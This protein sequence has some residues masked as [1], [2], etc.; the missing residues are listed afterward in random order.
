MILVILTIGLDQPQTNFTLHRVLVQLQTMLLPPFLKLLK[1]QLAI[2]M[3][4]IIME[5]DL[6]IIYEVT[7]AL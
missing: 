7:L 4:S 3:V 6:F 5:E 2:A 1:L